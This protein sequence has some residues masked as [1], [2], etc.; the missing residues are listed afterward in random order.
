[1]T[2][3]HGQRVAKPSP[4]G[5]ASEA[6]LASRAALTPSASEHSIPTNSLPPSAVPASSAHV[7]ARRAA[8]AS[9]VTTLGG[10]SNGLRARSR[11]GSWSFRRNGVKRGGS[12]GRSPGGIHGDIYGRSDGG[13]SSGIRSLSDRV[14]SGMFG[15]RRDKIQDSGPLRPSFHGGMVRLVSHNFPDIPLEE[16]KS[17]ALWGKTWWWF[18]RVLDPRTTRM[19][20]WMRF[21]ALVHS[22][23]LAVDP[24]FLY[25]ISYSPEVSCLFL[26]T[27]FSIVLMVLRSAC[28]LVFLVDA[29]LS[30]R[31]AY[32]SKEAI[33]R[34]HGSEMVTNARKIARSRCSF[35][36]LVFDIIATLPIPQVGMIGG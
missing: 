36:G 31:T 16:M 17:D 33:A 14:M 22:A 4:H 7:N 15:K 18:G 24:C 12:Q 29:F 20:R 13:I 6:E 19:K 30:L 2:S 10:A 35:G 5:Q 26:E 23:S 8:S 28:D 21:V 9:A 11:N 1:M 25:L 3:R 27:I 34:G 32:V